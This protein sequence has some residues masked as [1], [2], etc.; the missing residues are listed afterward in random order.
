MSEKQFELEESQLEQD[1][2]EGLITLKEFNRLMADLQR[3]YRESARE[4]S[5]EA[6]DDEMER[7]Q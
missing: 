4:A 7:W 1:L 5:Q 2:N 6:Y 3:D